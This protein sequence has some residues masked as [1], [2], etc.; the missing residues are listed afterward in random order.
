MFTRPLQLVQK[1]T[2]SNQIQQKQ[3]KHEKSSIRF[4][5]VFF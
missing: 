5:H 2:Y 4:L 1:R 3:T